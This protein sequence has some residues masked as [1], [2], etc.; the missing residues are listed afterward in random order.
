MPR[1]TLMMPLLLAMAL[2]GQ[3]AESATAEPVGGQ[4]AAGARP[5]VSDFDYQVKYQRAF[6]AV[7]WSLPSVQAQSGREA[8][9][10]GLGARDNDIVAMSGPATPRFETWTANSS[11]PYV[12][13]YSDLAREPVVLEVP[14]AGPDGSLYGQVTDAW[15]MTIADIGPSGID[16]GKGG[17]L[18]LTGPD[19]K[20]TV[21][22]G[23]RQVV[24]PTRR[25]VFA[26]RSVRAPGKSAADA[27]AYSKRLKMYYLSQA[28]N[29]PQQRFVDAV[30]QRFSSLLPQDERYFRLLHDTIAYEPARPQDRHMLGLLAS[31]GIEQGKPYQP[32]EKTRRAMRQAVVDVWFYLQQRFDQ[33]P[34]DYYYWPDRQY[35]PLLLPD[36]NRGFSFEYPGRID[37]DGR[38]LAFFWCTLVPR[39][40]PERPAA[41]YLMAMADNQ[42]RPL[43]AGATYRLV[44]PADMP[45]KQFWSLTLYDRAT[46]AFI[47]T[48]E[49]RT[50]LDSYG[51]DKMKKNADG[52][53]TL[54]VGPQAPKGLEANWIPTGGK[55]P[56]PALRF[57][58]A[59]DALFDK[60]FKMPDFERV[61]EPAAASLGQPG[62]IPAGLAM[63]SHLL[64]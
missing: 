44:V 10:G 58:G 50:T 38:A 20:G 51:L 29:P 57:Y 8:T 25:I 45:V 40:V 5:S 23:Y 3:A 49:G 7:L 31:L 11:T 39:Q 27:Y 52:S 28:A 30:D 64:P 2:Q 48:R 55:R 53:V 59:T 17:K 54:Y 15:Q 9:L 24:S 62:V 26:F 47:Y 13:A 42:G 22:A 36:A 4:P 56:L 61:D 12:F 32:D 1:R 43:E 18:L 16:A 35:V 21:P 14:P 19:F 63:G 6:E 46:M 37:I 60:R 41:Y 33:L 34:K